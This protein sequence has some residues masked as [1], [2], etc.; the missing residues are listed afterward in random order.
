MIEGQVMASA[1]GRASGV[2]VK[3]MSPNH[4]LNRSI[5]ADNIQFG[6]LKDFKGTNSVLIGTRL[7]TKLNLNVGDKITLISPKGNITVFGT[8]PRLRMYQITGLFNVGM[9]EYD[10]SFIFMPLVAAQK[11]FK[12]PSAVNYLDV[13][14]SDPDN[15]R[16][17]TRDIQRVLGGKVRFFNWQQSNSS[18]F[19]AIEVERNVMF[20]ILTLIILVAAF[21]IIS[22]LI[23]LVKDK[24]RDIAILR[25][26]GATKAMIPTLAP[27]RKN[28]R[29]IIALV[30]PI[31]RNIAISRLLSFTNIIRLEIM[32]K[33]ATRIIS[34]RI[35][36]ITLRST[37]RVEKTGITLLPIKKTDLTTEYPLDITSLASHVIRIRYFNV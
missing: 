21:N 33:A 6:S 16:S 26:M 23:M 2:L 3:G 11:Y 9:H 8:V 37:S 25:T 28:M 17:K 19:N 15:V 10:S 5:I 13:K 1:N 35:K 36:N 12:L 32:L 31:V 14:I 30:A 34:V 24:S 18:I 22:S 20:L 4:L 29:I 27:D 7:A